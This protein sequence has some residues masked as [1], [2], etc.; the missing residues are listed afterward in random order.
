MKRKL[1]FISYLEC[2]L[3]QAEQIHGMENEILRIAA[4]QGLIGYLNGGLVMARQFQINNN[5]KEK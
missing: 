4:L 3:W 1:N 5:Q 2:A